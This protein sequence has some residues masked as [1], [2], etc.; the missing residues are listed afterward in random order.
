[1]KPLLGANLLVK[2]SRKTNISMVV[3][4]LLVLGTMQCFL[5]VVILV[6]P[7]RFYVKEL[8]QISTRVA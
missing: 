8:K 3:P 1:M 5:A 4:V 7:I 2:I 6:H